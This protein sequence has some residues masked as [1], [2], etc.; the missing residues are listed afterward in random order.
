MILILN[1]NNYLDNPIANYCI[2]KLP[3][4]TILTWDDIKADVEKLHHPKEVM[5]NLKSGFTR[6]S[7]LGDEIRLYYSLQYDNYLYCDADVYLPEKVQKKIWENKNCV[8]WDPFDNQINNGTFFCSDKNCKFNEYYFNLYE[9]SELANVT[10]TNVYKK[11][12]YHVDFE[13][14]IAGDMNLLS[15][16]YRHFALSKIDDFKRIVGKNIDV[17]YYTFESDEKKIKDKEPIYIWKMVDPRKNNTSCDIIYR[18]FIFI[19]DT[20]Y[21]YISQD[22][23]VRLWKDQLNYSFQKNLKFIEC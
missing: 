3:S 4:P 12:P 13:K 22:D 8:A 14:K 20:V 18:K 23:M 2:S 19:W 21:E 1:Y 7:F 17:V 6:L 11:F 5:N 16:P 9:T 15:V 10:N